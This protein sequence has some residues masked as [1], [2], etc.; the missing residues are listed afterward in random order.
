MPPT[1][2]IAA[3]V[4]PRGIVDGQACATVCFLPAGYA[5][6]IKADS[7]SNDTTYVYAANP[8]NDRWIVIPDGDNV[9]I[10]LDSSKTPMPVPGPSG[11]LIPAKS[12]FKM[13]F[14][15][16][17][18]SWTWWRGDQTRADLPNWS[19]WATYVQ[20]VK[21]AALTLQID[22]KNVD[23][24][25]LAP[26]YKTGKV[27]ADLLEIVLPEKTPLG[28]GPAAASL[29]ALRLADDTP[30]KAHEVQDAINE[31]HRLAVLR[32][33]KLSP[34]EP[35]L[36]AIRK[37]ALAR[38]AS[39][40][41]TESDAGTR[42]G[43][44]KATSGEAQAPCFNQTVRAA[45]RQAELAERLAFSV[46]V[47]F[48]KAGV[49]GAG[50]ISISGV[51]SA[52]TSFTATF[53]PVDD[54]VRHVDTALAGAIQQRPAHF[55][56]VY[57]NLLTGLDVWR[58]ATAKHTERQGRHAIDKPG[59][60]YAFRTPATGFYISNDAAPPLRH[61]AIHADSSAVGASFLVR[62][63]DVLVQK[64]DADGN[65]T[66]RRSIGD[67]QVTL[68]L[69]DGTEVLT[70]VRDHGIVSQSGV[71][72]SDGTIRR[73]P[74]F[75]LWNGWSIVDPMPFNMMTTSGA[76]AVPNTAV[77]TDLT[78][79]AK[80]LQTPSLRFNN[81]YR[82]TLVPYGP[83]ATPLQGVAEIV[84]DDF[85][86]RRVEQVP[87]PVL[88]F[89]VAPPNGRVTAPGAP[90][91]S[92]VIVGGQTEKVSD[93]V[94]RSFDSPFSAPAGN[95]TRLLYR[96]LASPM[97]AIQ[98]GKFDGDP[99]NGWE[100]P[101]KLQWIKAIQT[102]VT[103]IPQIAGKAPPDYIADPLCTSVTFT[104]T[105]SG[106]MPEG[107]IDMP[108]GDG[109]KPYR[110]EVVD[111][112]LPG[113]K[114]TAVDG[115]D[116]LLIYM[117]PAESVDF[118][119]YAKL[120]DDDLKS[121]HAVSLCKPSTLSAAQLKHISDGT[122]AVLNPSAS[123]TVTRA[124]QSPAAPPAAQGMKIV[125]DAHST[126]RTLHLALSNFDWSTYDRVELRANWTL[127]S[128]SPE[129]PNQ[130]EPHAAVL[131][132]FEEPPKEM[133]LALP[134]YDF[135]SPK[136]FPIS[137]E[138]VASSRFRQYYAPNYSVQKSSGTF[139]TTVNASEQPAPPPLLYGIPAMS[140]QDEPEEKPELFQRTGNR[141]RFYFSGWYDSGFGEKLAVT[142]G[143][144]DT[145]GDPHVDNGSTGVFGN[146]AYP[147]ASHTFAISNGDTIKE[148][149]DVRFFPISTQ[150]LLPD[151]TQATTTEFFVDVTLDRTDNGGDDAFLPFARFMLQRYQPNADDSLQF[152]KPIVT[153][154]IQVLPDRTLTVTGRFT[155]A[156]IIRVA[157]P[158]MPTAGIAP[159][160]LFEA[161]TL[162]PDTL[163]WQPNGIG[164]KIDDK[165]GTCT[166]NTIDTSMDPTLSVF[167]TELEA[168][169]T[170]SDPASILGRRVLFQYRV[171]IDPINI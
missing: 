70:C 146:A 31:F 91:G 94:F 27:D 115:G 104:W 89:E 161:M 54:I 90:A 47:C 127:T 116:T 100:R 163:Q 110:V 124:V 92:D 108:L 44:N 135:H 122:T 17:P 95:G 3:I 25:A 141:V 15:K 76:P 138:L 131:A 150:Q 50:V 107:I 51:T 20:A 166:V 7:I 99:Q 82:L 19:T 4:V 142:L 129:A 112:P 78:Q 80:P 152:S 118:L 158:T 103:A 145:G 101:D 2:S 79:V 165:T 59:D 10:W 105:A 117:R 125:T 149:P 33:G 147:S 154:F 169:D 46:R 136:A 56:H 5:E 137:L 23:G 85:T 65:A 133:L 53:T 13:T 162:D 1:E 113:N 160:L 87:P 156:M 155:G 157:R 86:Y 68:Q 8:K 102:K 98:H 28:P 120:Q 16:A 29:A 9:S 167:V 71:A 61:M 130:N 73:E 39:M 111:S 168:I 26:F 57:D 96:P 93:I 134:S 81:T 144:P 6:S 42:S 88:A 60:I 62:G 48:P 140:I 55:A 24:V 38:M 153:D 41:G 45:S 11:Y 34:A 171:K 74:T 106:D 123:F 30:F 63:Y 126:I 12:T 43:T 170:N 58:A 121:M 35:G 139:Q 119:M 83:D 37:Y 21:A 49:T 69:A 66:Y 67:R 18:S 52:Q 77:S 159:K 151:I 109:V 132:V 32:A 128:A 40:A 72:D 148:H 164:M 114:R 36:V 143:T 75:G 64:V 97:L 22:G 14:D 84:L